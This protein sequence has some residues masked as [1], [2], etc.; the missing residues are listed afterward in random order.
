VRRITKAALGGLAGCALVLGGTELASGSLTSILKV[1]REAHDV[2]IETVAL[3]K[4]K[5][6][7]KITE[8]ADTTTFS[9]RVT[10]ITGAVPGTEL[11]SHLHTGKC[12]DGDYGDPLATP[13]V[14]A[15]SQAGPHYNHEVII[16]GKAFPGPG[17]LDPAT[18]NDQ[19]EV[20]FKLMP[21][22]EGMAYD[23]T[24]VR[25]VPV[26][27]DGEMAIV[28][29]VLPTNTQLNYPN[30]GGVGFAGARQ[31]CFPV[32]VPQWIPEPN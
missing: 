31:A 18:I 14:P 13:P 15:G 28:I 11:G 3:D 25:F 9:I 2:H 24:T 29:H 30:P 5:A 20:W 10:G 17:V 12:V 27:S 23:E 4:A 26:D 32:A 22:A 21:D 1:H 7:I 16:G 19:T 8:G 6:K